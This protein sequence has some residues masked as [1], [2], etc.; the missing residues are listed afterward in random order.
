M[1]VVDVLDGITL[2]YTWYD[3]N[4]NIRH[5]K[6]TDYGV[7]YND[8]IRDE[9]RIERQWNLNLKLADELDPEKCKDGIYW[10]MIYEDTF[11]DAN[12]GQYLNNPT[13]IAKK[14]CHT[15]AEWRTI[16][17]IDKTVGIS[18]IENIENGE[19][20]IYDLSGRRMKSTSQPGIYIKNGKKVVV[21]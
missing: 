13:S 2:S 5:D 11:G 12:F 15:N 20:V 1:G 9:V 14:Q 17:Q 4:D 19:E 6:V 7:G 3:E 16:L 10:F 21:R 8:E 18:G